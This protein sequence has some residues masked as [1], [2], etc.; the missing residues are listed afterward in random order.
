[1]NSKRRQSHTDPDPTVA[2]AKVEWLIPERTRRSRTTSLPLANLWMHDGLVIGRNG[3]ACPI[4]RPLPGAPAGPPINGQLSGAVVRFGTSG[5]NHRFFGTV[6]TVVTSNLNAVAARTGVRVSTRN[7][8]MK[9]RSIWA[10]I[11]LRAAMA[12]CI[13][14]LSP[15][16]MS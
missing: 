13:K 10:P 7:G 16:T 14:A 5:E 6:S 1:M 11:S 15:G 12:Q 3:T 8:M 9:P 2:E 4:S